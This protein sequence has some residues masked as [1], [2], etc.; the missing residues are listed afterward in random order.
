MRYTGELVDWWRKEEV[1]LKR[2]SCR[3]PPCKRRHCDWD[4]ET[5]AIVIA[6]CVET[7]IRVSYAYFEAAGLRRVFYRPVNGKSL[8]HSFLLNHEPNSQTG[9]W[10]RWC[11][12]ERPC[13]LH[14][15]L[16]CLHGGIS[17]IHTPFPKHHTRRTPH[18]HCPHS[19]S[20]HC[21]F[22]KTPNQRS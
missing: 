3:R 4:G 8:G 5:K 14:E 2:C 9:E 11:L 22:S 21:T 20:P 16:C 10:L 18:H 15:R 7:K 6:I 19:I 1:R 17:T 13:Y 12:H